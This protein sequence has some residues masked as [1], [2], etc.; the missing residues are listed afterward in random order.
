MGHKV[1]IIKYNKNPYKFIKMTD[2]FLLPSKFE[3]YPNVLLETI[4]LKKFFISSDCL[5]VPKKYLNLIKI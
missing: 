3:G 1:K 4:V 5:L 2:L